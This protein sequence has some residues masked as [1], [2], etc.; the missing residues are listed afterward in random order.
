MQDPAD[1]AR[2]WEA[3]GQMGQALAR[4]GEARIQDQARTQVRETFTALGAEESEFEAGWAGRTGED[5][6]AVADESRAFY[7]R[8]RAEVERSLAWNSDALGAALDQL[9]A[10]EERGVGRALDFVN[11]KR[12]EQKA[13]SVQAAED[14]LADFAAGNWQDMPAVLERIRENG[15]DLAASYAPEQAKTLARKGQDRALKAALYAAA[16][17]DP[18]RA[19]ALLNS[20]VDPQTGLSLLGAETGDAVRGRI[21]SEIRVLEARERAERE[22]AERLARRRAAEAA[23]VL[24]A[25]IDDA[26]A[27]AAATGKEPEGLDGLLGKYAA[28]GPEYAEQAGKMAKRITMGREVNAFLLA[29]E[30]GEDGGYRS[31]GEQAARVEELRPTAQDGAAEAMERYELAQKALVARAK[32][33]AADPAAYGLNLAAKELAGGPLAEAEGAER[34][35]LLLNRSLEIQEEL[36][37]MPGRVLPRERAQVLAAQWDAADA[38]GRLAMLGELE[39]LGVHRGRALAE[40]KVSAGVQLAQAVMGADVGADRDARLL[41]TAATAKPGDLPKSDLTDME[42]KQDMPSS[43]VL[44]AVARVAAMQPGNAAYQAWRAELQQT[45]ANA[46]RLTGS[47]GAARKALDGHFEVILSDD[48]AL[49]VPKAECPDPDGLEEALEAKR[50]RVGEFLAW[51]KPGMDPV[52]WEERTRIIAERGVWVNAPDGDGFV[53]LNPTTGRAITGEDGRYF[54]YVSRHGGGR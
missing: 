42:I 6:F 45:Y 48:A 22:E 4:T 32:E 30:R 16:D 5:R 54:R 27:Y 19:M 29:G 38:D 52:Q 17:A 14:G 28:L 26:Q 46:A 36:T 43:K 47:T 20:L 18:R 2:P 41:L 13:A 11:T 37:G 40:M 12:A 53:L 1:A 50:A 9:A 34:D 39:A 21:E 51:Q 23:V 49:F 8:K 33:L 10:R 15:D 35:R 24:G 7:K 3:L 31:L 44:R 25:K